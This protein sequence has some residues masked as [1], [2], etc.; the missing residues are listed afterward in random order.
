MG[1]A[2]LYRSPG[3]A[4]LMRA[5]LGR[6]SAVTALANVTVGVIPLSAE[7]AGVWCDHSFNILDA[8]KAAAT[9]PSMLSR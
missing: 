5:Q 4:A 7:V 6:L 3:P 8:P 1:A 2:A 9:R